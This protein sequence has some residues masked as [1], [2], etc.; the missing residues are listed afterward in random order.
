MSVLGRKWIIKN[1]LN[2][3]SILNVLL[4]NRGLLSDDD[5]Q[6]FLKTDEKTNFHDPF[7]MKDMEKSVKRIMEAIEKNERI[8]IF[9]DY[10]VDGLTSAAIVYKSLKKLNADH[11]V[12]LPNREKDGYGLSKKFIEE[13][14]KLEIKLIITVDCGISCAN[15]V[16]FAKKNGIDTIITDHHS[17]PENFPS[18]AYSIN[19][20][21]QKD[22][23]YPFS[24]LTGAGVALKLAHALFIWN[25]GEKEAEEEI[26]YLIE[27]AALGTIGDIGIMQ[28]ENRFIVKRGLNNL[29][30]TKSP[31]LKFL[32]ELAGITEENGKEITVTSVGYQLAPRINAAGRIGDPYSALRLLIGN[33][34][35]SIFKY[36]RE[37]EELN[38]KR[39]KMTE[40]TLTQVLEKFEELKQ[41]NALPYILIA[42]D[43]SWHV[44]IIGLSASKLA[45]KFNRPAIIMQDN[46]E[47]LV[48]SAR[49]IESFDILEAITK[50][51]DY[52]VTFGGNKE[53]AGFTIKKENLEKFKKEISKYAKDQLKDKD[54]RPTLCID[55]ELKE[56]NIT[57][58]LIEDI[59]KLKPFGVRNSRPL[60][61]L[62]NVK[63]HFA[64]T[65]GKNADHVK[66]TAEIGS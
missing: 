32:K 44:G 42:E 48:A 4:E 26:E 3:E 65:V 62:K 7:L 20:P 24:E 37:L 50:F 43:P 61:M 54:L 56:E 19:H 28:G 39:Q 11:S 51:K 41:K 34:E 16:S 36:G 2:T 60:F 63:P 59:W 14:I 40:E 8:I 27:L 47:V 13:F 30:K 64:G 49:S 29:I 53:A 45:E 22:C 35:K 31:G 18:D 55:C 33:D 66:F 6:A 9:G 58:N 5:K 46:G 25:L 1:N 21:K 17:I 15:E 10:D 12:R 23:T 38:Q 52:L 57:D